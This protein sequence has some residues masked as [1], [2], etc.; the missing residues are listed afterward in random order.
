MTNV[1]KHTR[2]KTLLSAGLPIPAD[3][4]DWYL[5]AFA[6]HEQEGKPLCICLG[7]R[8][9]G[10]RSAKTRALI[11]RRDTLLRWAAKSCTSYPG[12]PLWDKC[13]TLA[14]Q[15][16]R[17]PRSKN[18]NPLLQHVFEVGCKKIPEL[19][20]GVYERITRIGKT[21]RYSP[22]KNRT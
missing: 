21:P 14:D 1:E 5:E 8:G 20:H 16:K 4:A 11:A 3:L 6:Q 22:S 17:Y 19:Q 18:E 10:I 15:I 13:Q 2:F 7:I 9:A 12:E